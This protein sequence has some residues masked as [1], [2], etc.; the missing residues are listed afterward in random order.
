MMLK[1]NHTQTK[2]QTTPG[3]D[4]SNCNVLFDV[5]E[6]VDFIWLHPV[7]THASNL[8]LASMKLVNSIPI[9]S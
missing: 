6:I 9:G 1:N 7:S 5:F 3:P 4:S 8:L 2:K